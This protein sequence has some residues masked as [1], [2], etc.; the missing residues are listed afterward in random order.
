MGWSI[1]LLD[2]P[3]GSTL[4][5]NSR[6]SLLLAPL[7]F[8][9]SNVSSCFSKYSVA[10]LCCLNFY[11]FF[12]TFY[13]FKEC[14]ERPRFQHAMV[15]CTE[16]NCYSTYLLSQS[17]HLTKY[18]VFPCISRHATSNHTIWY[19]FSNTF[20]S[21]TTTTTTVIL[22]ERTAKH[23]IWWPLQYTCPYHKYKKLNYR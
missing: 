18:S 16:F 22:K 9:V 21:T 7:V 20:T 8:F 5:W 23:R 1:V 2:I 15:K 12:Y 3:D 11:V 13:E 6:R 4:Q 10:K 14:Q 17:C 19:S